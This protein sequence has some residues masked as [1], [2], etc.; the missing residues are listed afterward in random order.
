M[1]SARGVVARVCLVLLMFIAH[2]VPAGATLRNSFEIAVDTGEGARLSDQ[3][4]SR[5]MDKASRWLTLK[6]IDHDI[7]SAVKEE[8]EARQSGRP[9]AADRWLQTIQTLQARRAI[10]EKA[11]D[12]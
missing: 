4:A 6:S 10:Y 1:V 5:G 2:I 9:K 3:N 8:A 11:P 7:K 12:D